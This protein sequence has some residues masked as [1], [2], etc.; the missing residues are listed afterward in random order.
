MGII[1]QNGNDYTYDSV[2]LQDHF[3]LVWA[4]A[5]QKFAADVADWLT[6][7]AQAHSDTSLEA[8]KSMITHAET[9][10]SMVYAALA[11]QPMTDIELSMHLELSEN[12]VR[13]RRV[14]LAHKGLVKSVGK[15]LTPSNRWANVW[16]VQQ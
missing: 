8:A 9:I 5:H 11:E 14:E 3:S 2:V 13:P 1:E 4:E 12:T 10:R 16:G 6:L 15:K 7:P